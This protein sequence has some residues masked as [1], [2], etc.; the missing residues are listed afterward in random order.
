MNNGTKL[1]MTSLLICALSTISSHPGA[2]AKVREPESHK[3]EYC[4]LTSSYGTGTKDKPYGIAVIAFFEEGGD[5]EEYV[6]VDV[7]SKELQPAQQGYDFAQKK[8]F[9][10]AFAKLGNDEWE[11]VASSPFMKLSPNEAP[12]G[13]G[14]YFKRL[15]RQ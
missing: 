8:A 5:R 3:W 6:R 13:V 1:L 4:A 10:K 12:D 15:K 14:I 11:L 9:A 2:T 7:D